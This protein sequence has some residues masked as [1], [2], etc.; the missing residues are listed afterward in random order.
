MFSFVS[1]KITGYI[2][3]KITGEEKE[4]LINLAM[5]KGIRFWDYKKINDDYQVSMRIYEYKRLREVRRR[6]EV[7]VSIV[8]KCGFPVWTYPYKNRWGIVA[9]LAVMIPLLIYMT[10]QIWVLKVSGSEFYTEPQVLALAEEFGLYVGARKNDFSGS[11]VSTQ[12]MESLEK[13]TWVTVNNK[14]VVGEILIVDA[15][16]KPEEETSEDI[17]SIVATRSGVITYVEAKDGMARVEVGDIVREGEVLIS[18][19]W[20]TYDTWG[21]TLPG[22]YTASSRGVVLAETTR[23]FTISMSL[24]E[25]E[26]IEEE[27]YVRKYLNFFSLKIPLNFVQ[28]NAGQYEK[29]VKEDD[30]WLMGVKMPISIEDEIYTKVSENTKV[31]TQEEAEAELLIKLK[32]EQVLTI[33]VFGEILSEDNQFQVYENNITLTSNCQCVENI[34]A[35]IKIL[36]E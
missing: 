28:I 10:G 27:T 34:G 18:G 7:K 33:G 25:T 2:V 13:T 4:R 22:V 31:L 15:I 26:Y 12:L 24:E 16:Q 29:E 21:E 6:C 17:Q 35:E 19:I 32:E 20:Q 36:L 5:K 11:L 14:G 30:L 3:V 9:G 8:K 23:I 1:R